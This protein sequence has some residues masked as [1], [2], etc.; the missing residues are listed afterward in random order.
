[1]EI[2][3]ATRDDLNTMQEIF[4]CARE[5]MKKEGNPSQWGDSRPPLFLIEKDFN[6]GR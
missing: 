3:K 2:R 1:M 4:R 5:Y 6:L